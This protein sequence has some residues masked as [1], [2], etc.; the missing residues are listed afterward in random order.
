MDENHG[1][2]EI[3][4]ESSNLRE[5]NIEEALVSLRSQREGLSSE[6]AELRLTILSYNNLEEK[7]DGNVLNFFSFMRNPLSLF[8]DAAAIMSITLANGNHQQPDWQI[9]L[10]VVTLLIINSTISYIEDRKSG[11]AVAGLKSQLALNA[12]VRR[13]R[14]WIDKDA[15]VLVP[16]DII[17]IK[18]GDIIPADVLL[19]EGDPLSIDEYAVTRNPLLETKNAGERVFCGSTCKHGELKALVIA[20]GHRATLQ[21]KSVIRIIGN[22]CMI[23]V[24][25]GIVFQT[26]FMCLQSRSYWK[27]I[28]NIL[29]LLIGGIPIAMPT[30]LRVVMAIGSHRLSKQELAGM[31]VL[32]CDKAGTLTMNKLSVVKTHIQVFIEEEVVPYVIIQMAAQASRPS[33]RDAVDI[34]V[35]E[36]LDDEQEAHD[37][38]QIIELVSTCNRSMITYWDAER[39]MDRI[40]KGSPEVILEFVDNQAAIRGRVDAA[41][42]MLEEKG[43]RSLAVAYH[44]VPGPW[45]FIGLLPLFDPPRF[46][47]AQTIARALNLGVN[48][49]MVTGDQLAIAKETSRI[50]GMRTNIFPLSAIL[51]NHSIAALSIEQVIEKADGF[52]GVLPEIHMWNNWRRSRRCCCSIGIA[53]VEATDAARRASDIVLTEPGLSV[54]I[55]A[56]ET[57]R[58]TFQRMKG[59]AT[60]VVGQTVNIVLGFVLLSYV[61]KFDFPPFMAILFVILNDGTIMILAKERVKPS[62]LPDSWKLSEIFAAGVGLGSYLTMTTIVFF[63]AARSTEF[64]PRVFKV[65]SLKGEKHFPE[66]AL[67]LV[68]GS[69][70]WSF[71]ESPGRGLVQVFLGAQLIATLIAVYAHWSFAGVQGIG[72]GWAGVIWLYTIATCIPLDIIKFVIRYALSGKAWDHITYQQ[73][74]FVTLVVFSL[75]FLFFL[76]F[77]FR[78]RP[79]HRG[80]HSPSVEGLGIMLLSDRYVLNHI[81]STFSK[82]T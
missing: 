1:L 67:R 21:I 54:I 71:L 2:E 61:W 25:V 74:H 33:N 80:Y 19:L 77:F 53:T 24:V 48:V 4:N 72:W 13:D 41:V 52:A 78:L 55:G 35:I 63:W 8:M 7:K 42:A 57:S 60:Y 44:R 5:M 38:I 12:K 79:T 34:A 32:L 10:G 46:D 36:A 75:F 11:V 18:A 17:S 27:I 82:D 65:S 59:Y 73:L 50:M 68:P 39:N 14:H 3:V 66:L 23:A 69:Q 43:F 29:V 81:C 64:F 56:V 15:S 6:D 26:A 9:F 62:P 49:K 28:D 76:F 40:T 47:S 20:A 22:F 45:H 37:G 16:G 30:V 31:D 70:G 51:G 58:A